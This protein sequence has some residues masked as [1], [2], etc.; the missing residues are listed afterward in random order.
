MSLTSSEGD[1]GDN[2]GLSRESSAYQ[3]QLAAS[4]SSRGSQNNTD[5]GGGGGG[6][7]SFFKNI[8]GSYRE[9]KLK[10]EEK[11]LSARGECDKENHR[12]NAR[13]GNA[14]MILIP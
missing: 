5:G 1:E 3:F 12:P 9:K 4:T 7:P 14:A 10:H 2:G 8:I 6:G 13:E 11:M